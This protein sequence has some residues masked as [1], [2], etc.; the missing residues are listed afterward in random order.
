MRN[1]IYKTDFVLRTINK[2]Y[3]ILYNLKQT[4]KQKTNVSLQFECARFYFGN[5]HMVIYIGGVF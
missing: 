5:K 2:F 1:F 4:N 3:K